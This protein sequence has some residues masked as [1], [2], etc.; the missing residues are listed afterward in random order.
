[1]IRGCTT[2]LCLLLTT[3]AAAAQQPV[4]TTAPRPVPFQIKAPAG[5]PNVLVILLDDVGFSATSAFGG[6]VN[7]PTFDMLARAGLRF[8]R[9]NTTGMCSPTRAA[10]LTGRNP[11]NVGIGAVV[12]ASDSRPGYSG[13]HT[14]DTAT[15]ATTLVQN[16]YSTAA[17]GKWHL[18]PEWETSQSGPFDRWPTG[19]GFE[20]FYGFLKDETDQF[21]PSLYEG[22]RPIMRPAGPNYH[23]TED[24][25]NKAVQWMREQHDVTPDK[26][27]FVYFAPG[28]THAPLQVPAAWIDR[29]RGKFDRGWDAMREETFARQKQL[30]VIPPDAKLT[31]RD[32][33]ML[34][35]DSLTPDQ[36]RFAARSMEVYAGFLEHTDAQVGKVIDALKASGQLSNTLIFYVAGDNGASGEGGLLG[37][38]DYY[39]YINEVPES[40]ALRLANIGKIGGPDAYAHYAAEWGWAMDTPFKWVKTVASHLGAIR[41]AM[42]V[43]WPGHITDVGGLRGQFT[44][45]S[46]IAPTILEAVHIAAPAV[47]NGIKQKPLDGS[48]FVYT[49]AD[50]AAAE[51]HDT[52]Y[53]EI[54]GHRS[55]YHDGWFAD[56]FHT[57][58]PWNAIHAPSK[59]FDQDA[60]EL[61][62]L[63]SDFSQADDLAANNPAKLAEMKALFTSFAARNGVLPLKNLDEVDRKGIPTFAHGTSATFQE[64]AIDVPASALPRTLNSSWSVAAT[65]DTTGGA[66]GVIAA[67]GGSSAGWSVY[68]DGDGRP[69]FTYHLYRVKTATIRAPRTLTAGTHKV[70]VDFDYDG[71]GIGKGGRLRLLV[72]EQPVGDERLPA[73]PAYIYEASENFDVGLDHGSPAGLYPPTA[74]PGYAFSGGHI[75][76]VTVTSR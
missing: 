40:D 64:G 74:S 15:I 63:R 76:S 24:L 75:A 67:L 73:T 34:A 56:A 71:G 58:L 29:Y 5:A 36:K 43:D 4:P 61:Y 37:S 32:P 27:I 44:Y 60:W 16:G 70:R 13:F 21:E 35:W 39:S 57:R 48:S 23:L 51:R 50:P 46:D 10:L 18:T 6:P 31:P 42:V 47:V 8:N 55:I 52:Q 22:T 38:A 59:P 53:F 45:V 49:F 54:Y 14:K 65:I 25:A 33:H 11:H 3:A 28:A 62:D 20:H 9:F 30:G 19:E 12:N 2:A 68:L 41:N 26:P 1:M 72:D 66:R 69:T 17:F 7:T